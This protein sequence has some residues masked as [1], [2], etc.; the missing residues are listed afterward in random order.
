MILKILKNYGQKLMDHNTVKNNFKNYSK[1]FNGLR[2]RSN[3][4][5]MF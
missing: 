1:N 4:I 2:R 5:L 3:K